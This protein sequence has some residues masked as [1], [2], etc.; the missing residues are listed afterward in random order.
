[1]KIGSIK[2]SIL[3]I[4]FAVLIVL[5]GY[6]WFG[7]RPVSSPTTNSQVSTP[8][9]ETEIVTAGTKSVMLNEPFFIS[10]GYSLRPL[11]IIEDS[12]CKPNVQCIWAG[13]LVVSVRVES[14]LQIKPELQSLKNEPKIRDVEI[15]L[16]QGM[17]L[18]GYDI[19]LVDYVSGKF[20]F[21]VEQ[22]QKIQK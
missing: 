8:V 6:F 7:V 16:G 13:R 19:T 9:S 3:A 4:I 5:I 15:T 20:V 18:N 14:G 10:G 11:K 2:K 12:R 21:K 17:V 1:M 22:V